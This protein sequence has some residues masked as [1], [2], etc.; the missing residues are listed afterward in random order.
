MR[1]QHWQD[2]ADAVLGSIGCQM[3]ILRVSGIRKRA[4]TKQTAGTAI[5]WQLLFSAGWVMPTIRATR[6]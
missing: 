1:I 3:L 4:S 2:V 5:G 6:W